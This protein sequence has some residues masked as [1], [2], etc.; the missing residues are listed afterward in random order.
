MTIETI[1]ALIHEHMYDR[2]NDSNNSN[3]GKEIKQVQERPY[4]RK[5]M[6]KS[7][8]DGTKRSPEYQ[9]QSRETTDADNAVHHTKL[10][11]TTRMPSKNR[12]MQKRSL[13]EDVQTNKANTLR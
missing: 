4:K 3:D 7:D 6:D 5:W 10:S 8:T 2:L 1:T 12:E 11:E 9:K 13:R